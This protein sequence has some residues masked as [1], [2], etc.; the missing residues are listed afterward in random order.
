MGRAQRI[1]EAT[2]R[3][4]LMTQTWDVAAEWGYIHAPHGSIRGVT[5]R[6]GPFIRVTSG[7][8]TWFFDLDSYPGV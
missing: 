7:P 6:H 3:L 4:E 1:R 2:H 8:H 5:V